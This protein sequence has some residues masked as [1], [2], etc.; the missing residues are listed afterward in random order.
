MLVVA[1]TAAV[2]LVV[3]VVVVAAVVVVVIISI[4][5]SVSHLTYSDSNSN[6]EMHLLTF[7][8]KICFGDRLKT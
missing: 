3:V 4:F 8:T 7:R 6:L 2:V 5:H 1:A